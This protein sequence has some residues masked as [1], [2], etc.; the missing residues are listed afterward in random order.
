M[1]S[2]GTWMLFRDEGRFKAIPCH[3]SG[4]WFK[5]KKTSFTLACFHKAEPR[6]EIGA[7][8]QTTR[9]GIYKISSNINKAYSTR[10]EKK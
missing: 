5:K 3:T 1:Y 9:G 2:V 4:A 7:K 10:I 6:T 8:R